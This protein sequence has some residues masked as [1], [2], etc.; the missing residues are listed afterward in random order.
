[1]AISSYCTVLM[2]AICSYTPGCLHD[3]DIR[4]GLND[5]SHAVPGSQVS[6]DEVPV[7]EILHAPS[8]L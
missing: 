3:C 8:N 7:T 2:A 6:V 5:S 4:L 1:M